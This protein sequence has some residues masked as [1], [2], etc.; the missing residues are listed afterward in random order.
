MPA[1][2]ATRAVCSGVRSSLMPRCSSTSAAPHEEEAARLPCLTTR[3]PAAAATMAAIVDTFTVWAR[4]PP[5][6]TT[7]TTGPSTCSGVARS[8][9]VRARPVTSATVSPLARSATTQAEIWAGVAVPD[10]ISRIAH[11][12]SSAVRC[13]PDRSAE[14]MAGQV[15]RESTSGSLLGGEAAGEAAA[16]EVGDCVG[17]QH[18]LQGLGH[19]RL[20]LGPLGQPAVVAPG[21]D[22]ADGRA[23]VDLVLG[24]AGDAHAARGLGLAVEHGHADLARAEP[25]VDLGL[26][27]ALHDLHEGHVRGGP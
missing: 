22:E 20:G 25:L 3:A 6:P 16:H 12:V 4:S 5:V 18:G 13:S 21:D 14:S 7:S 26:G 8:S 1:S 10:M 23:V 17:Q 19:D 2:V 15:V 24:L 27:S 11:A 9:I